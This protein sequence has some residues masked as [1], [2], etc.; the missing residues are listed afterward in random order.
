MTA[1]LALGLTRTSAARFSFLLAIPVGVVAWAKDALDLAFAP[2]L[3][4]AA[5]RSL[6]APGAL[7]LVGF[8][9][10]FV[11]AYFAIGFLLRLLERSSLSWFVAYRVLLGAAILLLI[12]LR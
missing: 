3:A 7:L 8:I 5:S 10:S 6:A 1:A 9:V 12:W 2:A 11:S 4:P